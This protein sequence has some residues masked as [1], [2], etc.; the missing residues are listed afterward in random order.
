MADITLTPSNESIGGFA[1]VY[2]A[3]FDTADEYFVKNNGR[4]KLLAKRGGT[5]SDT[6]LTVETTRQVDGLDVADRS[7][8]L[9]PDTELVF[10]PFKPDVYNN[11]DGNI[12]F[13]VTGTISDLE[14][15][16][17]TA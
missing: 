5:A 13:T 15:A 16:A 8:T 10:G 11:A 1:P 4:L 7:Y 12:A 2:R 9:A 6:T 14:V 17:F 3:S